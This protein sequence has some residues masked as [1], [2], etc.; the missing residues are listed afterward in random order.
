[1]DFCSQST[2]RPG[3][4]VVNSYLLSLTQS[5][6]GPIQSELSHPA[7]HLACLT[8][9]AEVHGGASPSYVHCSDV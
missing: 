8:C 4:P 5:T 3:C 2:A 9:L 7:V 1:M 6:M